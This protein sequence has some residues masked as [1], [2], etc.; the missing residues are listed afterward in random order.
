MPIPFA[1]RFSSAGALVGLGAVL[2]GLL[3][4][5][6]A[7]AHHPGSHARRQ[8]DGQVRLEAIVI[9]GDAC[10]DIGE[11]ARGVPEAAGP[12]P[13]AEP[14]TIRLTRPPEAICATVVRAVSKVATLAVSPHTER[15]HLYVVDPNG[16]VQAT[17]RVPIR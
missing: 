2:G 13:G 11:I 9:A 12:P 16:S 1:R 3:L 8:A 10:T 5:A 6:S 14:V 7:M 15:L 4:A 17:E